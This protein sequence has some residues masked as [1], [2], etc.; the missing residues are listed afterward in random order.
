MCFSRKNLI[1]LYLSVLT[2]PNDFICISVES[3]ECKSYVQICIDDLFAAFLFLA[4]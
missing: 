2:I 4:G 3:Y 1:D